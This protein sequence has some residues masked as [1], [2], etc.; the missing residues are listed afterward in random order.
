[1][2]RLTAWQAMPY[3]C[4]HGFP[5]PLRR[6][7]LCAAALQAFGTTGLAAVMQVAIVTGGNRGIGG[8]LSFLCNVTADSDDQMIF[9]AF[10]V[11]AFNDIQLRRWEIHGDELCGCSTCSSVPS[12]KQGHGS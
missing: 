11:F 2:A 8:R 12:R 1:M 6:V 5:Q 7:I 4:A 9:F 3:S 10:A